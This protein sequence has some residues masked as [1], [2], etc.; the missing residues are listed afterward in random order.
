MKA[1]SCSTNP[2]MFGRI[3]RNLLEWLYFCLSVRL[4]VFHLSVGL[5]SGVWGPSLYVKPAVSSKIKNKSLA[6]SLSGIYP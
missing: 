4:T 6:V 1:R 5:G 3:D 2:S